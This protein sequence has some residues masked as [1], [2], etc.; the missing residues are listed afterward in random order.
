MNLEAEIKNEGLNATCLAPGLFK[1]SDVVTPS[2]AELYAQMAAA[3]QHGWIN[4][5]PKD[6]SQ[7]LSVFNLTN[8]TQLTEKFQGV[9]TEIKD[10]VMSV[11]A[12]EKRVTVGNPH[13]P[14]LLR[15]AAGRGFSRDYVYDK[16]HLPAS[17]VATLFLTSHP[18][19]GHRIYDY[20]DV[21]IAPQAGTLLVHPAMFV[22]TSG[23]LVSCEDRYA[24]RWVFART[25]DVPKTERGQ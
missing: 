16:P 10:K 1:W 6:T 22:Y 8:D 23:D 25:P 9:L 11:A 14:Q 20:F 21:Q 19:D 2:E 17:L 5:S 13:T 4:T 3:Q 24:L 15:M 12:N 7:E 18:S